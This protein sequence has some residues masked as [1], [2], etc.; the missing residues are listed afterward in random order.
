MFIFLLI[1]HGLNSKHCFGVKI[2]LK[3]ILL[4]KIF[5]KILSGPKLFPRVY[6]KQNRILV[7]ILY[8]LYETCRNNR[9]CK[10]PYRFKF[11][12]FGGVVPSLIPVKLMTELNGPHEM[13]WQDTYRK[14]RLNRMRRR[15]FKFRQRK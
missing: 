6:D 9:S 2:F 8:E 3:F 1:F 4:I 10:I 13:D 11:A 5:A 14:C 7:V 15:A 12:I